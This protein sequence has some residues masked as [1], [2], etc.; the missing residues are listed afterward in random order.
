MSPASDPPAGTPVPPDASGVA[1]AGAGTAPGRQ[2]PPIALPARRARAAL[3]SSRVALPPASPAQG[4][5]PTASDAAAAG[6]DY[7]YGPGTVPW[8]PQD[9][10]PA[11][12]ASGASFGGGAYQGPTGVYAGQPPGPG[13]QRGH[14]AGYNEPRYQESPGSWFTPRGQPDRGFAEP[15][16]TE[17][18]AP[19]GPDSGPH[20]P[21][22]G[23]PASPPQGGPSFGGPAQGGPAYGGPA[24]GGPAFGGPAFGGAAFG[25][26]ASVARHS[27]RRFTTP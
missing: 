14:D 12:P 20:S 24:Y 15:G 16:F 18:G 2:R 3:P 27:T 23:A 25:G 9:A 22:Q 6:D 10:H 4:A 13:G 11:G 5:T 19:R 8:Q 1:S 17:R 26:A 21:P 7:S